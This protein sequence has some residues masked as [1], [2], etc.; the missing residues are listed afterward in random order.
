MDQQMRGDLS[1]M[2]RP[3]AAMRGYDNLQHTLRVVPCSLLSSMVE[4]VQ[5]AGKGWYLCK[6]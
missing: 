1:D 6:Q 4:H 2:S 5:I 3:N